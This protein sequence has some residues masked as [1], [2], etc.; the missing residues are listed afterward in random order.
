M[1]SV[2][3]SELVLKPNFK[4]ALNSQNTMTMMAD[5]INK[6]IL[7]TFKINYIKKNSIDYPIS[8]DSSSLSASC[9]VT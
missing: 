6:I 4:N 3:V 1:E 5:L 8:F 2:R 7:M 9:S